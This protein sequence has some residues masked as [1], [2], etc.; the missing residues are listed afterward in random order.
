MKASVLLTSFSTSVPGA[1]LTRAAF[2]C[3][4][5]SALWLLERPVVV[6]C[7]AG[8]TSGPH[9]CHFPISFQEA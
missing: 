3:S 7:Q 6:C 5:G 2:L 4:A 9:H 1:L 8:R